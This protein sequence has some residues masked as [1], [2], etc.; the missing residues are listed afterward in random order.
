MQHLSEFKPNSIV[1][2]KAE[3]YAIKTHILRQE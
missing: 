1:S 3:L 2:Y